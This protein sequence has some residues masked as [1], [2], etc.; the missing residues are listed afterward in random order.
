MSVW[1]LRVWNAGDV[2]GDVVSSLHTT[3]EGAMGHLAHWVHEHWD[4]ELMEGVPSGDIPA[5]ITG[6]FTVMADEY[7]YIA[8][9]KY[10]YGPKVAE[11]APL[12]PD[13]II[14]T[15]E[16]VTACVVSLQSAPTGKLSAVLGLNSNNAA[17]IVYSAWRKLTE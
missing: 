17:R 10:I 9:E 5:D 13:E 3:Q 1:H 15:P 14:L 16:E 7:G 12:G 8:T 2:D 4:N 11:E 6:F